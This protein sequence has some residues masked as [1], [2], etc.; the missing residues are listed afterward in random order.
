MKIGGLS[1]QRERESPDAEYPISYNEAVLALTGF[2]RHLSEGGF[3]IGALGALLVAWGAYSFLKGA[4]GDP[5][6][7][8][9]RVR[10]IIGT[11]LIALAF[12]L[13]LVSLVSAPVSA[14]GPSVTPPTAS[15]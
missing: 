9:E 15:P 2:Y 3:L 4:K 8:Q 14:P 1:R 11:A 13:Q 12:L 6:R 7:R 10:T 5:G